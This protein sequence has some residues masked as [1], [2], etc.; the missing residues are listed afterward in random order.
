MTVSVSPAE[1]MFTDST[2]KTLTVT[3]TLPSG[4]TAQTV[5][6]AP[7]ISANPTG[8]VTIGTPSAWTGNKV[9]G[10]TLTCTVNI[11]PLGNNNVANLTTTVGLNG[12]YK[13]A[14]STAI[15][16]IEET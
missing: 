12:V 5:I 6:N 10:G 9:S 11:T 14:T 7:S 15:V 8:V 1:L 16:D 13:N 2:A 4:I 3:L